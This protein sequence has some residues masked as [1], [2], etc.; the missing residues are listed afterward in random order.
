MAQKKVLIFSPFGSWRVHGQLELIAGLALHVRGAEVRI[1]GCDGLF[2]ERCYVLAHSNNPQ[3]DCGLCS[4]T[5]K[6]FFGASGL[7][8]EQLRTYLTAEDFA[9]A[10]A[11]RHA[12]FPENPF[13]WVHDGVPL[14][15]VVSRSVSS[16]LRANPR[17]Y[18]LPHVQEAYRVYARDAVLCRRGLERVLDSFKPDQL[19]IFNG[20]GNLHGTALY[21]AKQRGI[22]IVTH[23][24]GMS[25]NTFI[26]NDNCPSG[27]IPKQCAIAKRWKDV[28]LKSEELTR[29][30]E[31]FAGRR[32][33]RGMNYQLFYNFENS[34]EDV[35]KQ[36][37]LPPGVRTFG[38]FSASEYELPFYEACPALARQ[39]DFLDYLFEIFK[40]RD[41][42]LVVRHHPIIAGVQSNNPDWDLMTRIYDQALRAPKNVRIILPH[43]KLNTYAILPFLSGCLIPGSTVSMEAVAMGIPTASLSGGLPADGAT[44]QFHDITKIE[45]E[46]VVDRL[47]KHYD[48][49]GV[50]DYRRLYR[51][52]NAVF[53][54]HPKTFSSFAIKNF[55]E[56]DIRVTS[57]EQL[58][59]GHDPELDRVCD[60]I[61]HRTDL[62]PSPTSQD[63]TLPTSTE[64]TF[65][66]A[67][68]TEVRAL[69]AKALKLDGRGSEPKVA[70]VRVFLNGA[71][72]NA[73]ARNEERQR[74][75][76][77]Q[78]IDWDASAPSAAFE[79]QSILSAADFDFV[80]FEFPGVIWD[81]CHISGAIAQL[82]E[83]PTH[84]AIMRGWWV[85]GDSKILERRL[86]EKDTL[87]G[88]ILNV[89]PF[90]KDLSGF[91]S[92]VMRRTGL[93]PLL[94]T[95]LRP[96][97]AGNRDYRCNL[98]NAV[99]LRYHGDRSGT[100]A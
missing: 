32:V 39:L 87:R 37:R 79:L 42:Y 89:A 35:A 74:H 70:I 7:P 58:S 68:N 61:L 43:E 13:R 17:M 48:S 71:G 63:F 2:R 44:E 23:D 60:H 26:V 84:S 25:E 90:G 49:F 73:H 28:P 36:L 100:A 27:D 54:R 34:L 85:Y 67:W 31:F 69:H 66:S 76:T 22:E 55:H 46:A 9:E 38:F 5:G 77:M 94:S 99:T 93:I 8:Y 81:E 72:P 33:G 59:A 14:G 19:I 47:F 82:E 16:L 64:E 51:F 92:L 56:A 95:M 80:A 83:Q 52:I 4:Q 10:D 91:V 11:I 20:Y 40:D 88:G 24:K 96:P 12:T 18:R 62:Y 45:L 86:I 29:V 15:E 6:D 97:I 21:L 50:D 1:I 53:Y 57:L 65:F 41:D 78:T 75:R 98:C 30:H 3:H